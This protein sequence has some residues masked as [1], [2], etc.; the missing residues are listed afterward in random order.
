TS[1]WTSMAIEDAGLDVR[2][3]IT[4]LFGSGFPKSHNLQGE[5][6]GWGTALKPAAEF[7]Y[8]ARKPFPGTVAAQVLAT[9]TGAINVDACRIGYQSDERIQTSWSSGGTATVNATEGAGVAPTAGQDVYDPSKGRWPSNVI[10]DEEAAAAL[11]AQ[12]GQLTSNS[13]KPF[14]RHKDK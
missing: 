3:C 9:G 5:W 7:W 10:L 12:S 11:D 8:L 13:G 4:H 6:Q 1:G 2:D 14:V